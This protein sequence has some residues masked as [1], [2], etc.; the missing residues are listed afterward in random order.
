MEYFSNIS[1]LFFN[2]LS[3]IVGCFFVLKNFKDLNKEDGIQDCN[4]IFLLCCIGVMNNLV[5][6]IGCFQFTEVTIFAFLTCSSLF[7]YNTYNLL[8]IKPNCTDYYSDNY[9]NIWYYYYASITIQLLSIIL[10]LIKCNVKL[11]C[12]P[13]I[14]VDEATQT[15]LNVQRS[16]SLEL[17]SMVQENQ[18]QNQNLYESDRISNNENLSLVI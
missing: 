16:G 3:F 18:N 9:P 2:L 12:K 4:N 13:N 7:G 17:N 5:P 15:L 10:Y 8:N 11:C 1:L 14:Q 6:I